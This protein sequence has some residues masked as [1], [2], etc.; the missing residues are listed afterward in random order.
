MGLRGS[1]VILLYFN[2]SGVKDSKLYFIDLVG[3]IF[4]CIRFIN[5]GVLLMV[6]IFL[7]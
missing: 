2:Y 7:K 1:Q 5:V 6:S 4:C 3:L